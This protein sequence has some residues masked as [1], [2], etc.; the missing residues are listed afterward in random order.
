[1]PIVAS[2]L[3]NAFL[4]LLFLYCGVISVMT[5]RLARRYHGHV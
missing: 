3:S 5:G 2:R 4:R 1:M